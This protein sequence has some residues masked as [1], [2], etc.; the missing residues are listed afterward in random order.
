MTFLK[1]NLKSV[2]SYI[3]NCILS[4]GHEFK[5]I[6]SSSTGNITTGLSLTGV[7]KTQTAVPE[8]HRA[9]GKVVK[10]GEA[11]RRPLSVVWSV[12]FH[13]ISVIF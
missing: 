13:L 8:R 2:S 4:L 5:V 3:H 10:D 9:Q 12:M 6:L 1:S 11:D 7:V